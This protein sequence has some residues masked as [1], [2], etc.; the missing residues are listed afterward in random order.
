M[1]GTPDGVGAYRE[2][3]VFMKNGDVMVVEVD[4]VG[5]LLNRCRT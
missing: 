1:T 3:P 5:R 2:S 4:R